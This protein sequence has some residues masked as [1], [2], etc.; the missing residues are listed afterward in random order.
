VS[1]VGCSRRLSW[2]LRP[3][4][5][6]LLEAIA[7]PHRDFDAIIVG[8]FE[9]AYCADEVFMLL[10]LFERYGVQLWLPEL[11]GP[12]DLTN[13]MQSL[14]ALP[15]VHSTREI[16]RARFRD[17]AAMRAQVIEHGRNLG[18]RPPY[19]YHLV[20]AGPH[21]NK[22]HARWGRK[23]LRLEPHPDTAPH[24]RWM[25]AQRLAGRSVAGIAH[26]LNVRGV[27]CPSKMDRERN[28]HR[29]GDGW[30][31]RTVAAILANPRYTGRQVWNKQRTDQGKLQNGNDLLGEADKR[32]WNMVQQW[33]ISRRVVHPPLASE[34]DFVAAQWASAIPTPP[35]GSGADRYLLAG[36]IRCEECGRILDSHWVNNHAAYRCRHG[37]RG[38]IPEGKPR[39]VYIHERKA[40]AQ[41]AAQLDFQQECGQRV[42]ER[43]LE[44]DVLVTCGVGGTIKLQ[45]LPPATR[46]HLAASIPQQRLAAETPAEHRM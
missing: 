31:L 8:E 23:A 40:I 6:L 21:P 46:A 12:V 36:L 41:L 34:A 25:F 33:A 19:G 17:K 30:T 26:D 18:G 38:A 28:P 5:A 2:A 9:R 39:I 44:H 3:Q 22:N 42:S 1:D 20:E 32:R 29:S 16:Q 13:P 14:L 24:V 7:S 15:G 37:V 10:P 27:A 4:A 35:E 43:L 11:H 45:P